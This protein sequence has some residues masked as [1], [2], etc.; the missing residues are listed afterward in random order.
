MLTDNIAQINKYRL[1]LCLFIG[2]D[3]HRH[4]RLLVQAL[5]SDETTSSYTWVLNN[6]MAATDNLL[7]STIFSNC[8]TGLGPAIDATFSTMQYL[9]CIFHIIQNIKKKLARF[10]GSRYIEFLADFLV[11][12][13]TLFEEVFEQRFESL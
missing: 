5:M 9:Y 6:M 2:V 12:R 10:L 13:N 8:D 3:E 11:C 4:L 1:A 7:P